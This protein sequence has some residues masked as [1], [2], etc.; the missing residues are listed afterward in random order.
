MRWFDC[1]PTVDVIVLTLPSADVTSVLSALTRMVSGQ[2]T[3]ETSSGRAFAP[4]FIAPGPPLP[5]HV[6]CLDSVW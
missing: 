4:A 3:E 5:R 2:G 1:H 6:T